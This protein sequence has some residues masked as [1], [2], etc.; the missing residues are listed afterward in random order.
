MSLVGLLFVFGGIVLYEMPRLVREGLWREVAVFL[1]I[2]VLGLVLSVLQAMELLH[3]S[4][5]EIVGP[6]GESIWTAVA[7]LLGSH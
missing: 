3:K 4:W 5:A 2:V 7:S 6:I 1:G